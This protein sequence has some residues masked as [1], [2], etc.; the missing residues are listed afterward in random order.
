MRPPSNSS[1]STGHF[2]FDVDSGPAP[3]Q[4]RVLIV[5]DQTINRLILSR[6]LNMTGYL[7]F[8]ASDGQ[9]ALECIGIRAVD[10]VIMDVEMPKMT[11]LEAILEIRKLRDPRISSLPV[12]A[13]TGNPQAE[14]QQELLDSGANAYLTKPFDTKVLLRTIADLLSPTPGPKPST[15]PSGKRAPN[16]SSVKNIS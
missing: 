5:D 14:S 2:G 15:E 11:G 12:L 10:L 4:F 3:N 1:S 16:S 13:A 8:E 6:L 7:T 9:E